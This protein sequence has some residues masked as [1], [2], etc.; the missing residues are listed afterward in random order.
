[1]T[2]QVLNNQRFINKANINNESEY[3]SEYERIEIINP[4]RVE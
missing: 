1:M 2:F 3:E 4:L